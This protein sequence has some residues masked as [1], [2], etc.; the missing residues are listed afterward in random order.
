[1]YEESTVSSKAVK[2]L[3]F[4]GKQDPAIVRDVLARKPVKG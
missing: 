3:S 4:A 1:M 2:I